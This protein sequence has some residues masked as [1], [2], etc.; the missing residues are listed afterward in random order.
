[1]IQFT[2]NARHAI[3][4]VQDQLSRIMG[5]NK[6]CG[7]RDCACCANWSPAVFRI[8][9]LLGA[10]VDSLNIGNCSPHLDTV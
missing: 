9:V 4:Q 2:A 10:I 7:N 3:V 6:V 5:D 8:L 1:M